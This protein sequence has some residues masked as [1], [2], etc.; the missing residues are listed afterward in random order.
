MQDFGGN[1]VFLRRWC[2]L[3]QWSIQKNLQTE[4]KMGK[5]QFETEFTSCTKLQ[6]IFIFVLHETKYKMQ[7]NSRECAV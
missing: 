2:A 7:E 6:N 4:W 1:T 3:T 5:Y